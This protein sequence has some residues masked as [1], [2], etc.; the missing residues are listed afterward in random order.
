MAVDIQNVFV[1]RDITLDGDKIITKLRGKLV[2]ILLKICPGLYNKYFL[3]K[4]KQKIMYVWMLRSLYRMLVYSILY[5]KKFRKE[6]ELIGFEVNS[7]DICVAN[8]IKHG[9]QQ[10]V[11]W[12]VDDLK[13]S[14]V[15]PKVN[16][17]FAECR[18]ENY[19]SNGLGH[20]KV[21]RGKIHG[22]LGMIMDFTQEGY[23]KINMQYY[24]EGML[25]EFTYE[26]KSTKMTPWT[27][28][29]LK[30]Q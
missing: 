5:Y 14:H 18:I 27:E 11:T 23:L 20:V 3:N 25:G 10:T 16:Q 28:K 7:Y 29:L 6:T 13:S 26:I 24:I 21:L 8:R 15:N 2:D 19:R 9:K 22:Y 1:Q 4:G 12:N 17:E 30:Y